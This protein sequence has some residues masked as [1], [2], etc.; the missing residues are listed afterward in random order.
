MLLIAGLGNPGSKYEKH[1]HNIGFMA[2]DAIAREHGFGPWRARFHG[3]V[4]EGHLGGQKVLLLKP[5]TFMNDSGISV[6]E[7][8]NFF[9][10]GPNEVYVIYDEIDLAPLKVRVKAGGGAAGHNGIRSIAS[11]FGKDFMRVRLGVGHPGDKNKVPG[12]VLHDFAKAELPWVETVIEAVSDAIVHLAQER[13]SEFMNRVALYLKD[14]GFGDK[15]PKA[16]NTKNESG[17]EA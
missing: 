8:A 16:K 10:L 9:K 6:S 4:S 15:P 17:D 1:R 11:H 5:G 2:V 3:L 7:A 14:R 12:Y 13:D